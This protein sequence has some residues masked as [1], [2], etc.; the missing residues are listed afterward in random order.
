MQASELLRFQLASPPEVEQTRLLRPKLYHFPV[1]LSRNCLAGDPNKPLCWGSPGFL[2]LEG[3]FVLAGHGLAEKQQRQHLDAKSLSFMKI[4]T[5]LRRSC[6]LHS[7]SV[8][9]LYWFYVIS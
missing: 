5:H 3:G 1:S 4:A 8:V 7:F 9:F 2:A 6:F